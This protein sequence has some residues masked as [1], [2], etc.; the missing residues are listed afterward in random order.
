VTLDHIDPMC[1]VSISSI[2]IG[3]HALIV[4]KPHTLGLG[5]YG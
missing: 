2:H 1:F 5:F 4:P 3:L